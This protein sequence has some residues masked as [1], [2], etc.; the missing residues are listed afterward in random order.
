MPEELPR[1]PPAMPANFNQIVSY[2]HG[3]RPTW[4]FIGEDNLLRIMC[5][6]FVVDWKMIEE[7]KTSFKLQVKDVISHGTAGIVITLSVDVGQ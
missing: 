2:I 1:T 7:L 3:R 6:Q 4:L 5:N